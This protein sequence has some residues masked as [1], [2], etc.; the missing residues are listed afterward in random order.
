VSLLCSW[1][2]VCELSIY[3]KKKLQTLHDKSTAAIKAKASTRCRMLEAGLKAEEESER[4][5]AEAERLRR[6]EEDQDLAELGAKEAEVNCSKRP[7][8]ER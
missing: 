8:L 7:R 5:A 2:F 6:L 3:T 4:A 1:L